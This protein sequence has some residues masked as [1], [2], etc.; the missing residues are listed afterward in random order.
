ME[1]VLTWVSDYGAVSLFFLMMLGIVGLPIPD[2]TLLV[3]SGYLIYQGR[4]NAPF[5]FGMAL[6]GSI[7]GISLSYWLGRTFGYTLIHKYGKYF[8]LT[9][10][11]LK[12]VHEWFE[13]IGRWSLTFGYYIAGVRH[14]TA[15][16]AGATELE[17]PVFALFAYS[18]ALL[19]VS[20]FL[21]LGYFVGDS[22]ANVSEQA[23]TYLLYG[24]AGL[25]AIL[26]IGLAVRYFRRR[27]NA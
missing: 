2:E 6:A 25:A 19:W 7:A 5:T 17:F 9:E 14:F 18:G 20:S 22:W 12:K 21:T 13:R 11:R 16:I 4:L 27:A 3:F 1:I 10:D 23:H 26:A 24:C 8:H 15:M